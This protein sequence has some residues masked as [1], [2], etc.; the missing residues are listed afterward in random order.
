[1]FNISTKVHKNYV[2]N[3]SFKNNGSLYI[4]IKFICLYCG[5]RRFNNLIYSKEMYK[6]YLIKILCYCYKFN[7]TK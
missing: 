7:L 2:H 6:Q 1:M 3:I 4:D 5:S